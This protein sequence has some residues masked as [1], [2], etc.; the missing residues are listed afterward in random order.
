MKD[1]RSINRRT[2]EME[3]H[4]RKQTALNWLKQ[5]EKSGFLIKEGSRNAPVYFWQKNRNQH[6]DY[7]LQS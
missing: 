6:Q 2:L 3:F 7:R 4:I 5:L 1:H